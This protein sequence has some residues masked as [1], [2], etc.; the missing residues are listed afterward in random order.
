MY[1][2]NKMRADGASPPARGKDPDPALPNPKASP[3]AS[4]EASGV[5]DSPVGPSS[6]LLWDHPLFYSPGTSLLR[7]RTH[8]DQIHPQSQ[9][10]V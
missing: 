6:L 3:P 7:P 9:E 8:M 1:F 2:S 4:T 10:V 5:Q